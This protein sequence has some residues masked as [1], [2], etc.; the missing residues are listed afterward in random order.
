MIVF[1]SDKDTANVQFLTQTYI[2]P[3]LI[4]AQ[5]WVDLYQNF[6]AV[7]KTRSRV[8]VLSGAEPF[9]MRILITFFHNYDDYN[10]NLWSL[11]LLLSMQ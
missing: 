6:E 2:T 7:Q 8:H 5:E 9:R 1:I 4:L 10:N 11:L 3:N